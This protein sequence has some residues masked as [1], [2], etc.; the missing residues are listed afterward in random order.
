MV[1]ALRVMTSPSLPLSSSR[2]RSV[3]V[4]RAEGVFQVCLVHVDRVLTPVDSAVIGSSF[5][6]FCFVERSIC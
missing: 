5:L 6:L 4:G 2:G 1:D 3:G